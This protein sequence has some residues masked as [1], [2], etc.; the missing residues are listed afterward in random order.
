M[1]IGSSIKN[2]AKVLNVSDYRYYDSA[3]SVQ[4]VCKSSHLEG[5][6]AYLE[7]KEKMLWIPPQKVK[8]R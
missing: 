5:Q 2:M 3:W 6:G 8:T 4:K 7:E 1:S